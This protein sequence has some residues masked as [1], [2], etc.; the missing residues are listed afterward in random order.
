MAVLGLI[1]GGRPWISLYDGIVPAEPYVYLDP[2]PG[3]P[4]NPKGA[5][6]TL[7][8]EGGQSP[9][10]AVA[11]PELVP[12]AQ[13]F[14]V[15]GSMILPAGTTKIDVSI[16]AVEPPALPTDGHIAGNV[17]AINVTNQAGAALTADPAD[18]VSI[19]LR[20]PDP[21]TAT[22]TVAR[23]DGTNWVAVT[24]DPAGVGAT[25]SA[26]VT[27]FGDFAVL[28]PGPAPS[29][30]AS[31]AS[32]EATS[33]TLPT[34]GPEATPAGPIASP[35]AGGLFSIDRAM[36]T[37][38]LLGVAIVIVLLVAAMALLPSRRGPP[39]GRSGTGW[40]GGSRRS[41]RPRHRRRDR[42]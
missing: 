30:A 12:Q 11:T 38:L 21:L 9:L 10:I 26:V 36:L 19:V 27:Q 41:D 29:N 15:P 17:Y 34:I 14:A 8:L 20:A 31:P 32:S 22:A 28:L 24:T 42:P 18:Q 37:P 3:Q 33:S 6:A 39:T 4:G 13:I 7:A 2:P 1:A 40:S 23:F 25:F 35:A 5:T 16:A